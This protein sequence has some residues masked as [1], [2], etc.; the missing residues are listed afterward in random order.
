MPETYEGFD[1][2]VKTPT[3]VI[4]GIRHWSVRY[5][6]ETL[7]VSRFDPDATALAR[8]FRRYKP[9]PLGWTASFDGFVMPEDTGQIEIKDAIDDGTEL[10]A[11]FH[12]D[13]DKYYHGKGLLTLEN[14]DLAWDAVG[15]QSFELQGT[16]ALTKYGWA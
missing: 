5:V 14:P 9:G 10:D 15:T 7:E 2:Y 6:Q 13:G 8:R 11:Y 12:L 4:G 16:Q 1:G 3:N